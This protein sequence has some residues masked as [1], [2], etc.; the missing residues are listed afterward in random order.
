MHGLGEALFEPFASGSS[1][2]L[3]GSAGMN[4]NPYA[5][6]DAPLELSVERSDIDALARED[7]GGFWRRTA[8][9]VLDIA[10]M[11]LPQL[12][13]EEAV[14][15]AIA[16]EALS[17][18]RQLAITMTVATLVW[19]VYSCLMWTSSWQATVGK[20]ICGLVV[21]TDALQTLSLGRAA[22]RYFAQSLLVFGVLTIP[23]SERR[24]ALHDMLAKTLVVKRGALQ[25]V[26]A[27]G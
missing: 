23:G 10:I 24:R 9:Y 27:L 15:F 22:L 21:T 1:K 17:E 2:D 3:A 20:R 25:N 18:I 4:R 26:A 11:A 5:P 19:L 16:D 6:P 8:A 12:A 7:F 14:M 13:L